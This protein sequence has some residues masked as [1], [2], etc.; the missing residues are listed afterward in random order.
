MEA[1]KLRKSSAPLVKAEESLPLLD[2]HLSISPLARQF[3]VKYVTTNSM[4]KLSTS[5]RSSSQR[6]F[7]LYPHRD[8]P[9]PSQRCTM[10]SRRTSWELGLSLLIVGTGRKLQ[11]SSIFSSWH[12]V[13]MSRQSKLQLV[14]ITSRRAVLLQYVQVIPSFLTI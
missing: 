7:S 6:R 2:W 5:F 1:A 9:M 11:E 14:A 10:S 12:S 4:P 3:S 13:K 8:R